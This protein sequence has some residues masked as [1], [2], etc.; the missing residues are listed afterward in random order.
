MT[1]HPLRSRL[2]VALATAVAGLVTAT[3]L[4]VPQDS[5]EPDQAVPTAAN[6]VTPG[7]FTGLGFDQCQAPSQRAMDAWLAHSPFR[8]VGI[9][10]SGDSRACRYQT[11]LNAAW[12]ATQLAKG[13]HLL[14][15][16]LGPQASCQPRFPRYSDDFR[17][18]AIAT[19]D[20]AKAR[21]QGAAEAV[22]N[23]TDAANLGLAKGSTIFYDLEGF[24]YANT[25]C[26]E[27]ALRFLSAWTVR[28]RE[29]GYRAGVYSSAGSGMKLLERQRV[30][31]LP[32]IALPDQIWLARYD[33]QAN[34]SAPQYLSDAGWVG[35]RIKQFQGGHNETWGGVTINIDRN[36]L[37][38]RTA[39]SAPAPAVPAA[40][41]T[42]PPETHCGGVN[43]DLPAYVALKPAN[44]GYRPAA[45]QVV[46]L[47]CLLKERARFRGAVAPG[48]G[49]ALVR[50]VRAWRKVRGMRV[51][52]V[53][54][55]AMWME[56]LTKGQRPN[57]RPGTASPHVRDVQR[58]LNAA[59]HARL[60][61][62]G[63]LDAQ[64]QA[65]L[66]QWKARVGLQPGN[67]VAQSAW[68]ALRSGRF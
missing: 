63:T 42:A 11:H 22:K 37:D 32:N 59:V 47:K 62:H 14:P 9:Y 53:W 30:S 13:W 34:T 55:R 4:V 66:R 44:R 45:D 18:S 3:A 46:A 50:S 65:V 2:G 60:P 64:T 51:N 39:P 25:H 33:G 31:P 26:R 7:V 16:A 20:Y 29:L 48:F 67:M 10:I 5:P 68:T 12:V 8:A 23:A 1:R 6:P 21:Q 43:V 35:N 57:L 27:S 17:I 41:P 61:V 58:A 49:P 24:D 52:A 36:Y 38:L 15:I 56:L 19:N 40:A 54:T 28:T